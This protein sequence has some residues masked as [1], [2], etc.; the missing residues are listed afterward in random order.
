MLDV[1][2]LRHLVAVAEEGTLQRASERL[3]ITQPAL[4]KS[5]HALE[6]FLDAKLFERKGRRLHLTDLGTN[7]V[8]SGRQ[9][10]RSVADT[11]KMVRDWGAGAAG[12]ITIGLGPAY[13]VL[14]SEQLIKIV[15]KDFETVQLR[16]ETGDTESL[17]DKL[18]DD[19][20]DMAICDLAMPPLDAGV[21]AIE[22]AAQPIVA[23]V[24]QGHPLRKIPSPSLA[25]LAS[26]PVGHSPAP[27]QFAPIGGALAA[28]NRGQSLCLS[29]NYDALVR[30]SKSSDLVTLLPLNLA[31]SYISG[32]DLV[33]VPLDG[34][35]QAS[36]PKI[37]F[38]EGATGLSPLGFRLIEPIKTRFMAA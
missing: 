22:L 36:M 9:I 16:L 17:V 21:T 23:L 6:A 3:H 33:I 37:L 15:V 5:I 2:H 18:L 38:R 34:I 8:E 14:L 28:A 7:L 10:L 1:R 4:T 19:A 12:S 24:N 32:G 29:E 30:T 20:I 31:Q 25:S 11:E 13:T 35:P 27:A 26:Y